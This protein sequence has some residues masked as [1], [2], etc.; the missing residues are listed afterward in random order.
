M[1]PDS[2]ENL[3]SFHCGSE[4]HLA[5]R[6]WLAL[7]IYLL[8]LRLSKKSRIFTANVA[9]LADHFDSNTRAVWQALSDL[10][11]SG[12]FVLVRSGRSGYEASSYEVMGH[13]DWASKNP[14]QCRQKLEFR[15]DDD[16][17]TDQLGR[18]LYGYSGS[19]QIRFKA[20]RITWYRK[21]KSLTD[22]DIENEFRDWFPKHAEAQKPR[23][24][25]WKNAVDFHF[26]K[27]LESVEA[28]R[29]ER[30]DSAAA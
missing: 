7:P 14:N 11:D 26:G 20:F 2:T 24:K 17:S 23:K 21:N 18:T 12:F 10:K 5:K 15:F 19:Y 6:H 13:K 1:N 29:G 4:V 27:H 8:A 28:K 30:S 25:K 16:A 3:S 9:S 22:S